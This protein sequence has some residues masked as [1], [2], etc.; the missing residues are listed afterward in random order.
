MNKKFESTCTYMV[1]AGTSYYASGGVN[2]LHK[3]YR[4]KKQEDLRSVIQYANDLIGKPIRCKD[5]E[6]LID[7]DDECF[8]NGNVEWIQV[9]YLEGG[10][11]VH[12][13]GD[14]YGHDGG[15][16]LNDI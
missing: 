16:F 10:K 6:C 5:N 13:N 7:E 3:I 11:I 9:F 4:N 1:F 12:E 8:C 2:D 14:C 15:V